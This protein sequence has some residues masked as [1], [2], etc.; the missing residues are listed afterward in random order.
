VGEPPAE[1]HA[2]VEA[3]VP[4]LPAEAPRYLMGVG[5]PA[6]LV[7]AVARG[8]DLFDCVIP[9]RHARNAFLYTSQGVVKLRN[10]RYRTDTGALDPACDCPTCTHYSRAYLHHLDRC[11]EILGARLNT[12]HNLHYYQR[13]MRRLRAAIEAGTL[14][15]AAAEEAGAAH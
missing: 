5:T 9:T 7:A 15:H 13:L 14:A 12:L 2:M 1:R 8:I 3:T 4:V 11:G 6:D 10:A